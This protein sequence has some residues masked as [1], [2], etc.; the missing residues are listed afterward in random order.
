MSPSFALVGLHKAALGPEPQQVWLVK[1]VVVVVAVLVQA[2]ALVRVGQVVVVVAVRAMVM[3]RGA[4]WN[5]PVV[6]Q[7]GEKRLLAVPPLAC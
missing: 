6:A 5:Q 3:G 1:V 4:Q 7:D 2:P